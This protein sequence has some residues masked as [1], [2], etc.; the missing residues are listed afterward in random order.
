MRIIQI[1]LKII[2]IYTILNKTSFIKM[3]IIFYIF[4]LDEN[5]TILQKKV[6][7]PMFKLNISDKINHKTK[8][9]KFYEIIHIF[10]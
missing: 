9:E 7:N 5:Y 2:Q 8:N 6:I 3:K 4:N 10:G 1:F